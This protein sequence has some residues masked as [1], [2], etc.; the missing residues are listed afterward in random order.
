MRTD[1]PPMVHG[2]RH[3]TADEHGTYERRR[4]RSPDNPAHVADPGSGRPARRYG[5]VFI[6]LR[7]PREAGEG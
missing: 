4:P 2:S 6:D 3:G 7:P 1:L 5:P